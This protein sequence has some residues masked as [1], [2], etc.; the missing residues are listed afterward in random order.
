MNKPTDNDGGGAPVPGVKKYSRFLEFYKKE[1]GEKDM[2]SI[3]HSNGRWLFVTILV[4]FSIALS[5]VLSLLLGYWYFNR[6]LG[7]DRKYEVKVAVSGDPKII[8]GDE[9]V[10]LVDYAN[11]SGVELRDARIHI[12]YPAGFSLLSVL[13]EPTGDSS[14][15]DL[16]VLSSGATGQIKIIGRILGEKDSSKTLSSVLYFV[17]HNF[18]S[19]FQEIGSTTGKIVGSDLSLALEI[20]DEMYVGEKVR[21]LIVYK[22]LRNEPL[23]NIKIDFENPSSFEILSSSVLLDPVENV[24]I[25]KNAV[26]EG[27]IA[28]EGIWG[29][30]PGED[31]QSIKLLGELGDESNFY[32]QS[33]IEK[34]MN[35]LRSDIESSLVANGSAEKSAI[36]PGDLLQYSLS[37]GNKSDALLEKIEVVFVVEGKSDFNNSHLRKDFRLLDWDV[38]K[39]NAPPLVKLLDIPKDQSFIFERRQM[40]WGE[41]EYKELAKLSPEGEIELSL[42]LPVTS[43]AAI[44]N[45]LGVD[46]FGRI[47]MESHFEVR[48]GKTGGKS[49]GQVI[50]S[51]SIRSILHSD[52]ALDSAIRY[53]DENSVPIGSGPLPPEVGK[54]TKYR[55]FW[56]LSQSFHES[57][58]VSVRAVLPDGVS[59]AGNIRV[60]AGEMEYDFKNKVIS[61]KINQLPS[62]T[63]EISAVFDIALVPEAKHSGQILVLVPKPSIEAVDLYLKSPIERYGK[64]LTTNLEGDSIGQGKGIVGE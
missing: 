48:V 6:Q 64:T 25:I 17:P 21:G 58:T 53:F 45:L 43:S 16:G 36:Y 30:H 33:E 60:G 13:P 47:E 27:E 4:F 59:W 37:I 22:S 8:S 32:R 7:Q 18:N 56:K 35:V 34:T 19:E 49:L 24:F 2:S 20:P 54:E 9:L 23:G 55:V 63:R 28:I 31:K 52:L 57:G 61:W 15:W 3:E 40:T 38:A 50:R 62:F 12:R 14:I 39:F 26:A 51:N 29:A 41:G 1:G 44:K 42:S 11:L 5:G 10:Y 46:D